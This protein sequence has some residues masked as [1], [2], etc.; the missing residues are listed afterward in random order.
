[1]KISS[2]T[3]TIAVS[4]ALLAGSLAIGALAAT[5]KGP[6]LVTAATASYALGGE[7]T[8]GTAV[9]GIATAAKAIGVD[10]QANGA[11]GVGVFGQGNGIGVEGKNTGG[12]FGVMGAGTNSVA[13]VIGTNSGTGYGVEGS[14]VGSGGIGV[15]GTAGTLG[16]GVE[17][18]ATAGGSGVYG[19]TLFKTG[20]GVQGNSSG[21]SAVG[22]YGSATSGGTGVSAYSATR[23]IEASTLA[24]GMAMEAD[25]QYG[26]I[27]SLDGLG[28]LI[29]EGTSTQNG[30]PA[31]VV[32]GRDAK[33]T[34]YASQSAVPSLEDTGEA[35]LRGG[36]AFVP[37]DPALAASI[38]TSA[39][40][41]VLITPEGD[42]RGLYVAAKTA[43][44]FVV[45]ELMGGRS[46]VD[47]EYRIVARPIGA[48]QTR[49]AVRR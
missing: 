33:R 36:A 26:H 22:V 46:T 19:T 7:N 48:K 28:N 25:N 23:A 15:Y 38:D 44:G 11:A 17:G 5:Q 14:N 20:F 29:L 35:Q 42:C 27:M 2:S 10:G 4:A 24:G 47:F 41:H 12:G 13:A 40:Y 45:R 3:F 49:L 39:P 30:T 34:S 6:L 21:P 32:A 43:R 31:I 1:M 37:I 16:Y 9:E 18:V 8:V